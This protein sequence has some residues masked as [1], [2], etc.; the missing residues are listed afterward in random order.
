M[1]HRSIAPDPERQLRGSLNGYT[2][3]GTQCASQPPHNKALQRTINSSVQLT[4]VAVWRH[5]L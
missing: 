4:L 5:T 1:A 2:S 3:L